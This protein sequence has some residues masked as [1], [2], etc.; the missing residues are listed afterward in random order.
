MYPKDKRNK[1][2]NKPSSLSCHGN[3]GMLFALF[4]SCVTI[5]VM[6][7]TILMQKPKE[8][9]LSPALKPANNQPRFFPS[10]ELST[11]TTE[12]SLPLS[13]L[14]PTAA[15]SSQ[16]S[17][18]KLS[19]ADRNT[20]RWNVIILTH[21]SSGSTFTGN[22]FN[23]HPDVFYLYEPLHKLRRGVYGNEWEP[24]TKTINEAYRTD[25]ANLFRDIFACGF[26][27]ETTLARAF[28]SFVRST[29]R[30]TYWRFSSPEFT[31]KAVRNACRAKKLTVAKI[32]QTRLPQNIGIQELQKV[33]SGDP[34]KFDCFIIHLVRDPRAVVSSML[35]RKFFIM[36]GPKRKL[37]TSGN[38]TTEGK[39][40][41]KQNAQLLCSQV[42]DNLNYVKENWSNW[43]KDRYK[44]V[45]Y[46]DIVGNQAN[47]A[48]ELYDFVGLTMVKSIYE[49]IVEGKKPAKTN[50][51]T[52][53]VSES[54]VNRIDHWRSDRDPSLV[55][56]FE[57]TCAPLMKLMGYT[58]VNGSAQLQHD[59]SKPLLTKD[60]P[61]LK[62][63]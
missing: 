56:L 63:L 29:K 55:S 60:I 48:K 53:T 37:L 17:S 24:F 57:E 31:N 43:F 28:P 6:V 8:F 25:F 22:I 19:T 32:M 51:A 3:H 33:C 34:T 61:L 5:V 21:M 20:K 47:S 2:S 38:L 13:T 59:L 49:W 11:E 36:G 27:E 16:L 42:S 39:K 40:L 54:D 10:P 15:R 18:A 45:R 44:L 9:Q 23:L 7:V 35:G 30:L 26:Q 58:F 14:S 46:E 12:D 50:A 52:F 41:V 62:D 1:E 4:V